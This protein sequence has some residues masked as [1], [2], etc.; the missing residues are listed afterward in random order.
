M[1]MKE[2][3]TD[4]VRLVHTNSTVHEAADRMKK[5]DV[6]A[7]PVVEGEKVVGMLTDRDI[8]VRAVA[9]K[10]DPM[11][12]RVSDIMT[13]EVEYCYVDQPLNEC[14]KIMRD[15]QIRRLVVMDR[16]EKVAGICS[17]GDI[18]LNASDELSEKVLEDVSKQ[19]KDTD[20]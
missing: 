4:E 19:D 18:A 15:K 5:F 13:P 7:L 8:T 20:T 17:L 9:N 1:Q 6:G 14:A 3:M 12:T 10:A 16:N 2:L 11:K